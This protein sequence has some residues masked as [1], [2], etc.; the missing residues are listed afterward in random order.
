MQIPKDI[1]SH[2]F[3]EHVSSHEDVYAKYDIA[4]NKLHDINQNF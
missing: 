3:Y 2:G 1:S 4:I